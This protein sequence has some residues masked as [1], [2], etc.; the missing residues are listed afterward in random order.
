M[1]GAVFCPSCG[2]PQIRVVAPDAEVAPQSAPGDEALPV[3]PEAAFSVAQGTWRVIE[4]RA[5][6]RFALPLAFLAGMFSVVQPPVGM[7]LLPAAVI[8]A[9][10]RYRKEY[11][12]PVTPSQG[13]WLGACTGLVSFIFF[14][15]CLSIREAVYRTEFRRFISMVQEQVARNPG[16]GNQPAIAAWLAA[17]FA[18]VVII[19]VLLAVFVGL[20]T[21]TG[22]LTAAFS[23]NRDRR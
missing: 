16:P 11:G 1:H 5:F 8:L 9:I 2:T 14:L 7:T 23:G 4:W 20:A 21:V 3:S 10:A 22:T 18:L 15:V 13:A 17:S 19:L 6:L 12:D